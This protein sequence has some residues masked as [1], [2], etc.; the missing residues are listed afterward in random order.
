MKAQCFTCNKNTAPVQKCWY[1][2]VFCTFAAICLMEF[3]WMQVVQVKIK[4]RFKDILWGSNNARWL[5]LHH[6]M[7]NCQL[8]SHETANLRTNCSDTNHNTHWVLLSSHSS[9]KHLAFSTDIISS[10]PTLSTS[11][12]QNHS[13]YLF[14]NVWSD[15]CGQEVR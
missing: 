4:F 13:K 11:L 1:C 10:C 2:F 15:N 7:W 3:T 14:V 12:R 8:S 6:I 9:I 5:C